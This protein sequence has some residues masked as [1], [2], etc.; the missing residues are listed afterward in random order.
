MQRS[1]T[2]LELDI[3]TSAS[4][5]AM[6]LAVPSCSCFSF[7]ANVS[8]QDPKPTELYSLHRDSAL[9][10]LLVCGEFRTVADVLASGDPIC[11]NAVCG[12]AGNVCL[13]GAAHLLANAFTGCVFALAVAAAA[14]RFRA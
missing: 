12:S 3:G 13:V 9:I 8:S 11:S 5:S 1:G 6:L 14:L 2:L 7:F 10:G 4:V